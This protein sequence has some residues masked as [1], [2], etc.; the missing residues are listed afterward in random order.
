[1]ATREECKS[2]LRKRLRT[3][4][5]VNK[6]AQ[7]YCGGMI[8]D[9]GGTKSTQKFIEANIDRFLRLAE[10]KD[11]TFDRLGS[12]LGIPSGAEQ[13]RRSR[14]WSFRFW[15]VGVLLGVPACFLAIYSIYLQCN[16][17]P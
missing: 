6:F 15:L 12:F 8:T 14:A 2:A 13:E 17:S 4:E 10:S 1:M 16:K 3:R 5:H 9:A 11:K 7:Q